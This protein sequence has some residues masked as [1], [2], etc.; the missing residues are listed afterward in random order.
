MKWLKW[1]WDKL[2]EEKFSCGVISAGCTLL[3]IYNLECLDNPIEFNAM[4]VAMNAAMILATIMGD[5]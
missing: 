4:L 2:A 1:F 3:T 5:D